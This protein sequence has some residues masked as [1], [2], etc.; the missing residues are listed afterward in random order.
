MA[1]DEAY[2]ALSRLLVGELLRW[3]AAK[4]ELISP[5]EV[6][7]PFTEE[8]GEHAVHDGGPQLALNV[9]ADDWQAAILEPAAP[10]PGWMQ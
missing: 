10:G 3:R 7:A 4:V 2:R 5:I 1:V 8:I 9:V 6:D